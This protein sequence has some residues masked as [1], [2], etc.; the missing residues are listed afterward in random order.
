M[1]PTLSAAYQGVRAGYLDQFWFFSDILLILGPILT[2]RA[3]CSAPCAHFWH[4]KLIFTI[5]F[6]PFRGRFHF[7]KKV[8]CLVH[9][10]DL[11]MMSRS[12]PKGPDLKSA[13]T[14]VC[15][16]CCCCCC[17]LLLLPIYCPEA[18]LRWAIK[19][20]TEWSKTGRLK[21]SMATF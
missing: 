13:N 7:L 10:S 8:V 4:K 20:V 16:C 3:S 19:M 17:C 9:V 11:Y 2:S 1:P 15:C 5:R 21:A 18:H 12:P 6:W 14:R